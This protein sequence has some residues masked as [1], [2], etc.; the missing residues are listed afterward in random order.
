MRPINATVLGNLYRQHAAALRLY[1]RQWGGNA[2]DAVQNAF[3]RLAQQ[4]P[5]PE[6]IPAWL[7]RVVR[8]EALIAQRTANRRRQREQRVSTPEAWFGE[9]QERLEAA[10]AG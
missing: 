10:E 2:E 5:P 1:A 4:A 8:N 6:Q 3:L 9:A 7:Y